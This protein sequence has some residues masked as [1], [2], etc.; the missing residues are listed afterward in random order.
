MDAVSM[1]CDVYWNSS[2][3][4]VLVAT[5]TYMNTQRDRLTRRA[6]WI[7][8]VVWPLSVIDKHASIVGVIWYLGTHWHYPLPFSTDCLMCGLIAFNIPIALQMLVLHQRHVLFYSY[9]IDVASC[10]FPG[11]SAVCSQ[12]KFS[13]KFRVKAF[14][15]DFLLTSFLTS[16]GACLAL[17]VR[18]VPALSVKQKFPRR[19][20]KALKHLCRGYY[21]LAF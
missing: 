9:W 20:L 18:A 15:F 21:Q 7:S 19:K 6:R 10:T 13:P 8:G 16:V 12:K 5:Q 1:T 4:L 14:L 2:S 11:V 3:Y 17:Q